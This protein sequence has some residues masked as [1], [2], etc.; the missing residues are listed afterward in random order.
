[1]AAMNEGSHGEMPPSGSVYHSRAVQER[2]AVS[3]SGLRRLA[4]I[5]ERAVRPLPRDERGRVWPEEAVETLQAAREAVREQRAVSIEAALKG[6]EV[7]GVSEPLPD[8]PRPPGANLDVVGAAILEELRALRQLLEVQNE[9][10]TALEEENRAL[11]LRLEAPQITA[12]DPIVEPVE[13]VGNGGDAAVVAEV[14]TERDEGGRGSEEG[15]RRSW[16]RRLFG[17]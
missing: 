1:M 16:W 4:A 12:D 3:P 17:L 2:L 10:L 14:V 6:Q 15:E 13:A 5:Y 7:E 8:A 9:R 11:R